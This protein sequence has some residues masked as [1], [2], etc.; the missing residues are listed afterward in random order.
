MNEIRAT[1]RIVTPM[2]L[3]GANPHELSDTIRPPS[4]KGALRFWWRAL[5]W[6]RIRPHSA[7]DADALKE[8]HQQ[9]A[10]LFG[11]AAAGA[12]GGQSRFSLRVSA[13]TFQTTA[14]GQVHEPFSRH[15]GAR[16]LGYG[17][18][19]AKKLIR[20]CIEP[21]QE[22]HV[23]LRTRDPIDS[24]LR[25]A[26]IA[27]GLLGGLGS[28]ARHGIGSVALESISQDGE[29][30]W[31]EPKNKEEYRDVIKDLKGSIPAVGGLPPYTAFSDMHRIDVLFASS[32]P[33]AALDNYGRAQMHYRSWGR[34]EK[35]LG[36]TSE[37]N[38]PNDHHWSKGRFTPNFH[39][40]RVVFGLPHNY[41]REP[42]KQVS[43]EHFH[44]R[45]TPLMFHV[46]WISSREFIGVS[47]LLPAK[48]LPDGERI[49]A[50]T[51]NVPQNIDLGVLSRF[52]DGSAPGEVPRFP[53]L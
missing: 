3:G 33:V 46:H 42:G 7:N 8:V 35:V 23:I 18:M 43:A 40:Q 6:S 9:E 4:I 27:W 11:L 17:L 34:N 36:L 26:L 2:F 48:F 38:F 5:A 22:F 51:R 24:T 53:Y 32:D 31:A 1:L 28:R 15:P 25:N 50:G 52:L 37:H 12:T 45:A 47:I 20:P 14:G 13:P 10:A 19:G 44:R 49:K 39:P 30:L 16:Y 29:K 41:G 21:G